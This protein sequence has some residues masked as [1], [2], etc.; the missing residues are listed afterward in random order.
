MS[1]EIGRSFLATDYGSDDD[2][3]YGRREILA[4]SETTRQGNAFTW[5]SHCATEAL[6][7]RPLKPFQSIA[8]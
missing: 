6:P 2:S 7:L 8:E 1:E 4:A 3:G 5:R